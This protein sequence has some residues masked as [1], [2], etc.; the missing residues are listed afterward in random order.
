MTIHGE[1]APDIGYDA[2]YELEHIA[3]DYVFITPRRTPLMR[4]AESA[5]RASQRVKT[6]A[7]RKSYQHA[8]SFLFPLYAL[9]DG[10]CEFQRVPRLEMFNLKVLNPR[11]SYDKRMHG[12]RWHTKDWDEIC[13]ILKPVTVDWI[14]RKQIERAL[15]V[16]HSTMAIWLQRA[17]DEG[18]IEKRIGRGYHNNVVLEYKWNANA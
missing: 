17:L 8:T 11:T 9:D 5:M 10:E 15:S 13:A 16:R 1:I 4:V 12:R 6:E 14:S 2:L 7:A 3:Y 18:R